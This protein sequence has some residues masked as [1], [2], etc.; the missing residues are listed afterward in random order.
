MENHCFV[1][2]AICSPGKVSLV[3]EPAVSVITNQVDSLQKRGI[4]AIAFGRAAGSSKSDNYHRVFETS[5][6]EPI[7][8]FCTPEY[9]FGTPATS[10]FVGT[11]GQFS[12][13][14]KERFC[15][16]TT[17]EAH[18]IFDHMYSYRPAFNDMMQLKSLS[19]P[20][21]AM[22]AT[23]TGCQVEKLRQEYLHNDQCVVLTKGV[24]RDNLELSLLRYKRCKSSSMEIEILDEESNDE[25]NKPQSTAASTTMWEKT[26]SAI[27]PVLDGHSTVVYLDFVKDVEEVADKLRLNGCKAGKYTGQ[28]TV[29][30]R[31]Q[32]DRK[33]LR[34]EISVLVATESYELGVDNPNVSQVIRI[35][36]LGVLLQEM[37]RAG[38]R[39]GAKA[40]GILLFNEYTDDKR[41]GLWLKSALDCQEED[42][43]MQLGKADVLSTYEKSWRFIYSLYHGKCLSWALFH[44]YGGADDNDPPTCFTANAPLCAVCRISD[45]ICQESSD[46][47]DYLLL[48]F[49][50]IKT[51]NNVGFQGVTKTLLT[52]VLL[53]INE[54]YVRSF[55][56][57]VDLLDNNDS[58]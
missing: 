9:L 6:N 57:M 5:N 47:Q 12:T 8:A 11:K 27:E 55:A 21:I 2:P 58:C 42:H 19:C 17:D 51:L 39:P 53:Q 45:A 28:M 7:V 16:I 52:A 20:I 40:N 35:V 4:Q 43:S 38:R 50:T 46:I 18:K 25:E 31:K 26:V 34:G 32:V 48:L 33:F 36:N 24:H 10:T 49:Q 29:D 1:I 37:G 44:F 56:E 23:L 41:L 15:L 30:D 14:K 3:V 22:S 54:Q 13:S